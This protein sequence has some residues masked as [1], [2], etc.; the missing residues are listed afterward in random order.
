MKK[1]LLAITTVTMISFAANAQKDDYG[2]S[3]RAGMNL[4][5]LNGETYLGN[6]LDADLAVRFHVGAIVDFPLAD[7]FHV[8]SGLL[9]STKGASASDGDYQINI[10]YFEIPFNLLYKT[11]AGSGTFYGGFGPYVGIGIGG[12]QKFEDENVTVKR[13]IKFKGKVS[14][15]FELIN[16]YYR[17]FDAGANFVLGYEFGSNFLVQGTLQAGLANI[18]PKV[19]NSD[20]QAEYKN[21]GI[22]FSLGYRL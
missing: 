16:P 2:L 9:F 7:K 10:S 8:Q 11:E 4:Q 5:K 3:I 6:D 13:D 21:F 12:K 18:A 14:N 22:Q 19:E 1:Y 20:A 15:A 17:R